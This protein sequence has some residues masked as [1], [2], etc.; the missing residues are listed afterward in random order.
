MIFEMV[1]PFFWGKEHTTNEIECVLKQTVRDY[2]LLPIPIKSASKA[3]LQAFIK[4]AI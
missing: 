4:H 2:C 3:W 1:Y